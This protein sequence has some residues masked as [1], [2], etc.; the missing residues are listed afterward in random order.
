[1]RSAGWPEMRDLDPVSGVQALSHDRAVTGVRICLYAEE[2]RS[3]PFGQLRDQLPE[4]GAI[5]DLSRVPAPICRCEFDSGSFAHAL[6]IV[7]GVLELPEFGGRC[8]LGEMAVPNL[9]SSQ[10]PLEAQR[11]RPGVLRASH[12]PA[13]ANIEQDPHL[14]IAEGV[15]EGLQIPLVNTDGAHALHIVQSAQTPHCLDITPTPPQ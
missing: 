10:R 6:A 7:L 12:P 3:A 9:R 2:A 15:K 11:V 14:S 5:K 8:K 4:V 13:L 1:M